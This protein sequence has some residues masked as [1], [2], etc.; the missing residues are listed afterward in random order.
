MKKRKG[1]V[2]S[3]YRASDTPQGVDLKLIKTRKSWDSAYLD[4]MERL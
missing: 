3:T 1:S 2:F 4:R